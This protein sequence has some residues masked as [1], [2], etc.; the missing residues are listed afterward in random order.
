MALRLV[1][2][3]L[4]TLPNH[5]VARVPAPREPGVSALGLVA[6]GLGGQITAPSDTPHH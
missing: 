5:Q 1:A 2:R 6:G 4:A 3:R